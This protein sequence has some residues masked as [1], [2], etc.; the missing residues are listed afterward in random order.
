MK[1]K[2]MTIDQLRA[3]GG[4]R[5]V[6]VAE[7]TKLDE[8]TYELSFSSE[9][10]VRRWWGNEVLSHAPGAIRAG[11]LD[12]GAQLLWNHDR[13]VYL[14][15]VQS[16]RVEGGKL[17]C[18]VRFSAQPHA[19]ERL[20]D[21]EAGIL[22]HTSV[23]YRIIEAERTAVSDEDET[24][25]VTSWEPYEVSIVTVPADTS[26]GAGRS[27]PSAADTP[28]LVPSAGAADDGTV[29]PNTRAAAAAE[30]ESKHM[31]APAVHVPDD[32]VIQARKDAA[33]ISRMGAE[34]GI[35]SEA[36][37]AIERGLTLEQF[38]LVAFR[39]VKQKPGHDPAKVDHVGAPV[40]LTKKEARSFSLRAAIL[41][42][43]PDASAA[44]RAAAAFEM[45]VCAAA[46]S[47][48]GTARSGSIVIPVD[49]IGARPSQERAYSVMNTGTSG[50][51]TGDTG[52][53]LV[54]TQLRPDMFIDAL[55]ARSFGLQRCT[56][57]SGLVGNLAVT[58]KTGK[59]T[60]GW[61]AEGADAGLTQPTLGN[62]TL[63]PKTLAA[64]ARL[65]RQ[66]IQQATPDA[67]T[68]V[69]DDLSESLAYGMDRAIFYGSGSSGE[70]TGIKNISG[71]LAPTLSDP[72]TWDEV[73]AF[74]AMVAKQ[75]ALSRDRSLYVTGSDLMGYFEATEKFTG[76]G[77]TFVD[78]EGRI[79]RFAVEET[80]II[81]EDDLFFGD[82]RHLLVG[83]WGGFEVLVDPYT[84][85]ASGG[86]QIVMFQTADL[87]ARHASAFAYAAVE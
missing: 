2:P 39:A 66:L 51:N 29:E 13:D 62:V 83:M 18:A 25:T 79:N 72:P 78:E 76:T 71:V 74:K 8:L 55:Y 6:Q 43:L 60:A 15:V 67:E 61:I 54:G 80:N 23:G 45:E 35:E 50:T 5:A 12:V 4:L 84:L 10:P 49:V 77:R 28:P 27:M 9:A 57:V 85:A 63:A 20:A 48:V 73:I 82:F 16:W 7:V 87:A 56:V 81:D 34:W 11:Y 38:S 24:W 42:H 37:D 70:P 26:V 21:L 46:R 68:I 33:Q 32:D 22:R 86:L 14:G 44:D 17:R 31:P 53:R 19:A 3:E 47:A 41:A 58:K 1:R 52:G 30:P 69:R 65:T 64:R 75:N 36:A 59:S 40:G